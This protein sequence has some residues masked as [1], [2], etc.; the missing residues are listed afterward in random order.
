MRVT[1]TEHAAPQEARP[2]F[3]IASAED[4]Q[5][6]RTFRTLVYAGHLAYAAIM[7]VFMFILAI[8]AH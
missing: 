5:L 6:M 4:G 7:G 2:A 1:R 3:H 8:V